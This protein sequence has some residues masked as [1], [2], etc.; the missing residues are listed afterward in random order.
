MKALKA[1]LV[2]LLMAAPAHALSSGVPST[3]F[4]ANTGC[5]QCHS[6]GQAPAVMLAG[7][8]AVEPGSTA[9][10]TFT[11]LAVG[12]QDRGGLNA[13]ALAGTLSI[14]G[15][16]SA[17]TRPIAGAGRRDEITHA[18]PKAAVEGRI[19]FSFLWTAPEEFESATLH[20][21]GNAVNGSGNES[22]DRASM[23]ELEIVAAGG[24]TPTPTAT[25]PAPTPT[26][27]PPASPTATPSGPTEGCVGDCNGDG[28]VAINEVVTGVNIGLE[29][30]PL[31]ACTAFDPNGNGVVAVNEIVQGVNNGLSGCPGS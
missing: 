10:Y 13:S 30:L 28:A 9:E 25:E 21:W 8:T 23:A 18:R 11:I 7:P 2:L 22:G 17:G 1:F 5:N 19:E 27:T 3:F 31:S 16:F 12:N 20:V 15:A 14:G 26:P 4:N 29:A 24:D 6:G